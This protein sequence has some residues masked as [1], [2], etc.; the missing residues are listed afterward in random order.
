MKGDIVRRG[1][2][3]GQDRGDGARCTVS[4]VDDGEREQVV[5]PI[6]RGVEGKLSPRPMSSSPWRPRR[7]RVKLLP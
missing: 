5:L 4:E 1:N 6:V 7:R 2:A 3:A